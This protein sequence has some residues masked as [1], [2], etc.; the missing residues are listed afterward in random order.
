MYKFLIVGF[1]VAAVAAVPAPEAGA[2]EGVQNLD[3]LQLDDD[4]FSCLAIKASN[5]LSRAA[6]SSDIQLIEGIKFVKEANGEIFFRF[7]DFNR[8]S[9]IGF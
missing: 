7:V 9:E 2:V 6:R 5:A 8:D 4:L 1:V 3:C